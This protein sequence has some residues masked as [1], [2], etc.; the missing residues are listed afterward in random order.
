MTEYVSISVSPKVVG[1]YAGVKKHR[2][3]IAEEQNQTGVVTGLAWTETG[4]DLLSI[5]SVLI[6]GKEKT[7]A[8][9]NLKD[10]MTEPLTKL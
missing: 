7:A 3:G 6:P 10:V 4:G 8:T 2:Y 5:E 9:G 1:K